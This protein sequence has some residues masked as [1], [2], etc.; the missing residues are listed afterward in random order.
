MKYESGWVTLHWDHNKC[1]PLLPVITGMDGLHFISMVASPPMVIPLRRPEEPFDSTTSHYVRRARFLDL[2]TQQVN[3]P[4]S[5]IR[6]RDLK[7]RA[8]ASQLR[9][10]HLC[11]MQ[12][13]LFLSPM[14]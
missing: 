5:K 9:T 1:L 8:A 13:E 4:V 10:S 6:F 7:L 2:L 12:V 3:V 11:R 14:R